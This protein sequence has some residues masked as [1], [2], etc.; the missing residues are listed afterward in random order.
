MKKNKLE[1]LFDEA[2]DEAVRSEL[3]KDAPDPDASWKRMAPRIAKRARRNRWRKR[4]QLAGLVAAAMVLAVVVFSPPKQTEAFLPVSRIV[5]GIKDGVA[6]MFKGDKKE[7][8]KN[9]GEGMLTEAPTGNVGPVM[10]QQSGNDYTVKETVQVKT[11]EEAKKATVT[12]LPVPAYVPEGY[13]LTQIDLQLG[14]NKVLVIANQIYKKG[15][16]EEWLTL[17][18]VPSSMNRFSNVQMSRDGKL[19]ETK[20]A[21]ADAVYVQSG[22]LGGLHWSDSIYSYQLRGKLDKAELIRVAESTK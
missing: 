6:T 22:D 20:V 9:D 8:S 18:A 5:D 3:G 21:G 10:G 14:S 15:T 16:G 1:E 12:H 4:M 13:A 2:F 7:L 19:E 17:M 11:L